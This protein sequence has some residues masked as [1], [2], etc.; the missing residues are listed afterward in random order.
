MSAKP[1]IAG[2]LYRLTCQ[3]FTV[4]VIAENAVDAICIG[5]DMLIDL[6]AV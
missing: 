3:Q 2:Q 6:E 5:I 1:I 4:D